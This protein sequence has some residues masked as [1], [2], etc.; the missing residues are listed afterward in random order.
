MQA[1]G[2][3]WC[4]LPWLGSLLFSRRNFLST[5]PSIQDI[6]PDCLSSKRRVSS[7][8]KQQ[9]LL[10]SL[11]QRKLLGT[12]PR[13]LIQWVWVIYISSRFLGDDEA[14]GLGTTLYGNHCPKA[15]YEMGW[16]NMS[17]LR[18]FC[19]HCQLPTGTN[20]ETWEPSYSH[21]VFKTRL[22]FI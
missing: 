11:L 6:F 22:Q 18:K 19:F 16:R 9:N 1:L 5:V 21:R 10:K 17:S 4:Y 7:F 12:I 3:L 15:P 13:I 14:V 2:R 8:S 20:W